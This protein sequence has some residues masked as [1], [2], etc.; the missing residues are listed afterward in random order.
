VPYILLGALPIRAQINKKRLG[1][2][3]TITRK[4]NTREYEL[5]RKQLA[6]KAIHSGSWFQ[7]CERL[8]IQYGLPSAHDLLTYTPPKEQWKAMVEQA[9]NKVVT[10]ETIMSAASKTSIK[11]LNANWYEIGRP[12]PIW[13]TV[14]NDIKDVERAGVK[15]RLVAGTYRLQA[16][17]AKINKADIS[18]CPL[19]K[20]EA[21]DHPHFVARCPQLADIRAKY[22]CKLQKPFKDLDILPK[23]TY[24]IEDDNLFT[25]MV[26]DST[27]LQWLIGEKI[28]LNLEPITR[29]LCYAL[30]RKRAS[31]V[32][33]GEQ[34]NIHNKESNKRSRRPQAEKKK[35]PRQTTD[36]APQK[37]RNLH[38]LN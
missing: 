10:R 33:A 18:T 20:R 22:M 28:C 2:L 13:A 14:D 35:L 4:V 11:Y 36:G 31:L 8:L 27:R 30:H 38:E 24:I 16:Q 25:Q 1:L 5:A 26:L 21:E 23:W 32:V 6:T 15:A 34:H 12:H 7:E 9:V 37:R 17:R 29:R 19:C 3:G